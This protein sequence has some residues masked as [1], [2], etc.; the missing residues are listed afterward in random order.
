MKSII[1][2]L[3]LFA[4][5]TACKKENKLNRQLDGNWELETINGMALDSGDY[6]YIEFIAGDGNW[7]AGTRDVRL[8][9]LFFKVGFRYETSA[10]GFVAEI[11]LG[12]QKIVESIE[13]SKISEDDLV[14]VDQEG[15]IFDYKSR[16]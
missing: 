11:D 8:D 13:V 9:T 2:P 12:N 3:L 4:T 6:E 16:Y 5:L 1:Y 15:K 10:N 7:G 14:L